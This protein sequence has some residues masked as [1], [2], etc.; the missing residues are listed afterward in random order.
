M[1]TRIKLPA[2]VQSPLFALALF[3]ALARI[4][5][6]LNYTREQAYRIGFDDAELKQWFMRLAGFDPAAAS[7]AEPHAEIAED[8][9]RA[10]WRADELEQLDGGPALAFAGGWM[11]C[12]ARRSLGLATDSTAMEISAAA[13]TWSMSYFSLGWQ[14]YLQEQTGKAAAVGGLESSGLARQVGRE[15]A[16]EK[17]R[18]QPFYQ[19]C[20]SDGHSDEPPDI[21]RGIV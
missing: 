5:V 13:G 8:L 10:L 6:E 17:V 18:R 11:A 3:P 16:Q 1:E 19:A 20:Q 7:W 2:S 4:Y 12:R 14:A 9:E 15:I 21:G